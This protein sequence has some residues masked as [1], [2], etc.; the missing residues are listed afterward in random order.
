MWYTM[1][2]AVH[3][4]RQGWSM[5]KNETPWVVRG[6]PE[7]VKRLVKIYA[8]SE[9]MTIADALTLLVEEAVT[10]SSWIRALLIDDPHF[11]REEAEKLGMEW[12][13]VERIRYHHGVQEKP[14]GGQ[15]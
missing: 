1:L 12:E 5:A 14:P 3:I 4:V 2:N 10:G 15:S 11:T 7:W 9:K 6:V 13:D 8:V